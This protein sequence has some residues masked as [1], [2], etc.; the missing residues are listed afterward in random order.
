MNLKSIF[1]IMDTLLFALV[2]TPTLKQQIIQIFDIIK[3]NRQ[4]E[5]K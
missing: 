2:K 3:E 4:Q 5:Y 1:Q